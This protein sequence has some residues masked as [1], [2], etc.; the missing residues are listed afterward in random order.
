MRALRGLDAGEAGGGEA[1]R[2]SQLAS[3]KLASGSP[4]SPASDLGPPAGGIKGVVEAMGVARVAEAIAALTTQPVCVGRPVATHDLDDLRRRA[5]ARDAIGAGSRRRNTG[6]ASPRCDSAAAA[7][8]GA[9]R[10]YGQQRAGGTGLH[11]FAAAD[12]GGGKSM[13]SSKSKAMAVAAPRR[14]RPITS[15]TCTSRQGAAAGCN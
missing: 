13:G 6:T 3:R 4:G 12:A 9:A 2:S 15:L 7:V 5:L 8:P 14:T 10:L 11:A 1:E